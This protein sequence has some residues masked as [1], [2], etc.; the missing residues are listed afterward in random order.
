M[1]VGHNTSTPDSHRYL[2]QMESWAA[3]YAS[4]AS[5]Q[6]LATAPCVSPTLSVSFATTLH[7]IMTSAGDLSTPSCPEKIF[8]F[9]KFGDQQGVLYYLGTSRGCT[10]YKNPAVSGAVKVTTSSIGYGSVENVVGMERGDFC[11]QNL[12]NSWV[13][14]ELPL[15]CTLQLSAYTISH[16]KFNAEAHFLRH[17]ELQGLDPVTRAWVPIFEHKNDLTLHQECLQGA[18]HVSEDPKREGPSCR[19]FGAFRL[20]QIGPNSHGNHYLMMSSIELY[21]KVYEE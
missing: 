16:D 20:L 8:E 5:R 15:A 13:C 3:H 21:G 7:G 18:W 14:V 6:R 1:M 4:Y 12:P 11:S 10:L 19:R 2:V 17:W 9:Q